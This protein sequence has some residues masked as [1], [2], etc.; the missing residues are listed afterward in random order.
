MVISRRQLIEFQIVGL[1]ERYFLASYTWGTDVAV[2]A[3]SSLSVPRYCYHLG[4]EHLETR[5]FLE[6]LAS[7]LPYIDL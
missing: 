7:C 1:V 4:N 3:P 6:E 2:S 5:R